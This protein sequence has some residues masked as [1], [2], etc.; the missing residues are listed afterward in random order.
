MPV[1]STE[2]TKGFKHSFLPSSF[3]TR[4]SLAIS[5]LFLV[6]ITTVGM[7]S[8]DSSRSQLVSIFSHEQYALVDRVADDIDHKLELLQTALKASAQEVTETDL[9]SFESAQRYLEKNTGLAAIF[10]RSVFVFSG[11]GT[12]LA[13]R[14]YRADR[15]GQNGSWRPYIKETMRTQQPVLSE[16]FQSNVGDGSMVVVL[17]TPVF[18]KNGRMIGMLT[19]S[20]GLTKPNMLG[21]IARTVIGK[22]GYLLIVNGDGKLITH[23]DRN[24]ISRQLFEPS[25]NALFDRALKGF[26]GT[27][28]S[29]DDHGKEALVSYKRIK[30][31]NWIVSAVYPKDE[32]FLAVHDLI[33]RFLR[34]L[35]LA[36]VVV[37]AAIWVLT[38]FLTR[39][40]ISLTHHI[41]EY[42]ATGGRIT[43]LHG[44]AG[45]GEVQI[46]T[47]AFN[48][49]TERLHDREDALIE[50]MRHY[51]I[52]TENSTDLITKHTPDGVVTYAS[53]ASSAVLGVSPADLSQRSLLELVHP[54]DFENVQ[55]AFQKASLGRDSSTITY[56]ARTTNQQYVW[57]EA[58]LRSLTETGKAPPHE[59]LC[60]SRNIDERKGMEDRLHQ[61]ARTDHLTSLPNR[62]LLEERFAAVLAH[63]QR[64]DSLVA[65]LLIDLDRFKNIND[66]LGHRS[67]DEILKLVAQRFMGCARQGDTLVRWGGD[68]YILLL[69]GLNESSMAAEIAGRYLDAL[70]RPFIFE[71]QLLHITASIGI[72]IS[73][74]A[75]TQTEVMLANADTA[76]YR[77]KARGGDCFVMYATEMS[78]GARNRLSME[79]ALF[80]AVER[81][82]LRLHYQPLIVASTGRIAG[83]EALLR[84]QHPELGLVPPG[85]FIPIAEHTGLI[86]ELGEWVLRTACR[87]LAAWQRAGLERM[88]MAVNLSSRQFRGD[89]LVGTIKGILA[90]TGVDPTQLELELTETLLMDD[91]EHSQALITELKSLGIKIALDDFGT[92]YSSLS[93][94]KR[95]PLDTLKIDRTFTADMLTSPETAAIVQAT[96]AIA[97]SLR[98]RTVAEGVETRQQANFLVEQGC[99]VLQGF[100]FAKPMPAEELHSFA[101]A[102]PT[103]LV[104]RRAS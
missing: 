75:G 62:L 8:L 80:H 103:Y 22:T 7:V 26:E 19:G 54:D 14:P 70:K 47:T 76:M 66:T 24:R 20:L 10:D 2:V 67:G 44:G 71:G 93:Y 11:D 31:S 104:P 68:E 1:K 97:K 79:S 95:F 46:L 77:A 74:D 42:K 69:P 51:Q 27:E 100:Y 17:T 89:K 15:L 72:S 28:E 91:V 81:D 84:W 32:A 52:I 53:P 12:L 83:V 29:V 5:L 34:L 99:D 96:L 43:P 57:L 23:P 55:Q 56:R 4:A 92:G 78:A 85:Q 45:N 37:L 13:E 61:Q 9:T 33:E 102:S 87:Q 18:A 98:L 16:P 38:Y 65:V 64:E 101:L 21:N 50:T 82:E 60:I 73:S 25:T 35:V 49:L 86:A 58:A 41:K 6:T 48:E 59:I 63:A 88:T 3:A 36:T 90:D 94:L 39:P 30:A 40:L